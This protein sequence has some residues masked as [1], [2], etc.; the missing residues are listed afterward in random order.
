MPDFYLIMLF[1]FVIVGP[2]KIERKIDFIRLWV[3]AGYKKG[4]PNLGGLFL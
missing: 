2:Y 1:F 4:L 3:V